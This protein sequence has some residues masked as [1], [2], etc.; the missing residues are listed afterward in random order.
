MSTFKIQT[1]EIPRPSREEA[2]KK[3]SAYKKPKTTRNSLV[4]YEEVLAALVYNP[5]TGVLTRRVPI[6]RAKKGAVVGCL[7]KTTGYL[8]ASVR[9][10]LFYCHRLAWLYYYGYLPENVIDHINGNRTDNSIHNLREVSIACN[11]RNRAVTPYN[12]SSVIQSVPG[13]TWC[14]RYKVWRSRITQNYITCDFGQFNCWVEA[15]AHR[16]AA[17]QH[18]GWTVCATSSK[19]FQ[20]LKEM[21]IIK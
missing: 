18:L 4:T 12:H 10:E 7:D 11:S 20:V 14:S 3:S 5:E 2:G 1:M 13:V 19:A 21:G 16:L 8:R 9:G 15:V 17:E 6:G